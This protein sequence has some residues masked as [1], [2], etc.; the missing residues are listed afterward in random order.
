M[1]KSKW[2]KRIKNA[3]PQW[4]EE[5]VKHPEPCYLCGK[6]LTIADRIDGNY[7][8]DNG[9]IRHAITLGCKRTVKN[10]T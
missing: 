2:I 5:Y 1:T 6:F 7:R 10:E 8:W 9:K 3:Q 4:W